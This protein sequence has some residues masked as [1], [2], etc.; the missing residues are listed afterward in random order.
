[1]LQSLS[2][3]FSSWQQPG[4]LIYV[5]P[6]ENFSAEQPPPSMCVRPILSHLSSCSQIRVAVRETD[7]MARVRV[8]HTQWG[9]AGWHNVLINSAPTQSGNVC[10]RWVSEAWEGED[11]WVH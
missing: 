11:A 8:Q 9:W 10:I 2:V 1:M 6:A 4:N 7:C 3:N 5:K